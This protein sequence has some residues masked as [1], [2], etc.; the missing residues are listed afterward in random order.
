[1]AGSNFMATGYD[2]SAFDF[3]KSQILRRFRRG[4]A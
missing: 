4:T 3:V 2:E 1:M